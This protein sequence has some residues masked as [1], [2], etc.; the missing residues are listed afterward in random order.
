MTIKRP[1]VRNGFTLIEVMIVVAIIGIIAAVA[2]PSYQ[3]HVEKTRR[4]LAKADLLELAQWMERRYATGFDYR[5]SKVNPTLPFKTSPRN[6]AEPTAY[7]LSFKTS[8]SKNKFELQAVPTT[9]QSGDS[10]GTL[11]INHQGVKSPAT[12]GC[13]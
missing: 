3:S 11:T 13:W 12:A 1:S 4:N 6:S 10:C 7:N 9:L 8:V 5:D 2:F